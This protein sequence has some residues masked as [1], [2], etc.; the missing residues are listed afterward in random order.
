MNWLTLGAY[1]SL[2]D[3]FLRFIR[4]NKPL[5]AE[6]VLNVFASSYC[7]GENVTRL[8]IPGNR[9]MSNRECVFVFTKRSNDK[10]LS[11]CVLWLSCFQIS[12]L[13]LGC[14]SVTLKK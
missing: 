10:P 14:V 12:T 4:D 6:R 7:A 1:S 13:S 3:Y 2:Y 11:F 9:H 8:R 5:L